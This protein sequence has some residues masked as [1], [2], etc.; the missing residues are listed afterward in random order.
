M[1]RV[2]KGVMTV[3]ADSGTLLKRTQ[4]VNLV[5]TTIKKINVINLVGLSHVKRAMDCVVMK[6]IRV[7]RVLMVGR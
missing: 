5:P 6:V 7:K 2:I 1:I 4:E 3:Q